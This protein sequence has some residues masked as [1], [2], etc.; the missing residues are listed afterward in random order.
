MFY[1]LYMKH[2]S[3]IIATL[4]TALPSLLTI[5]A[6]G[7]RV[8]RTN[9]T[10]SDLDLAVLVEGYSTPIE[11]FNLA[12]RIGELVGLDV[13]LVDFRLASTVFQYQILSLGE[14]WWVRNT[15]VDLYEAAVLS[16]KTNLDEA[17]AGLLVDIAQS[18]K[19]YAR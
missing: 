5:Y 3:T 7:S 13:D 8:S 9:Q 6:F 14:R 16:E 4:Q 12:T 10:D 1:L 18:G 11:L 19:I 2:Q 17:R 15:Q